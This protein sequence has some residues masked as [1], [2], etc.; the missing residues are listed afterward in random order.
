[1]SDNSSSNSN[2]NAPANGVVADP[3]QAA[4]IA[5][6]QTQ[7][8][9]IPK[10]GEKSQADL[11][12][13]SGQE[14]R[15]YFESQKGK[16]PAKPA[17]PPRGD[18]GRFMASSGQKQESNTPNPIKEAAEQAI[19]AVKKYKVKVDGAEVEVDETEL[20][21]GYTHA[22]AANKAFQEGSRARKQA[23]EFINMMKDPAKFFEVAAKMGHDPRSLAEKH[24]AEQLKR[25]LM[26][27]RERELMEAKQK[28]SAYEEA[29]QRHEA[30][31]RRQYHE[32]AK[33][34]FAKEYNDKFVAALKESGLPP[35]KPMVAEMAKYISQTAKIGLE[36]TPAEAAQMVLDD[37]RR[38]QLRL[39]GDADGETLLKLLGDDVA[40]KIR[41]VDVSRLKNPQQV[42]RSPGRE[43]QGEIERNRQ[44]NKRMSPKEWAEFK[45]RKK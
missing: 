33:A 14:L 42:L 7:S 23:E 2:G 3:G 15:E 22:K 31:L 10:V 20:L 5:V 18:D 9:P 27:P 34:K 29:K 37:V 19:E 6:K 1:M 36:I 17:T 40:N 8:Q 39:I 28:L 21:R 30:E 26:D 44:T 24:L 45:R 32:Q 35:S 38:A 25:E 41:Q 12:K 16:A 13:M 4:D 11:E 43:E